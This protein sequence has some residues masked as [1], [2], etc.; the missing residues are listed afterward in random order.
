MINIHHFDK[1]LKTSWIKKLITQ[2]NSL[3][4]RLMT[5]MYENISQFLNFGDQWCNK[6]AQNVHNQF[7]LDVLK[8]W[9][10][11]IR[12]QQPQND[13][14][15]LRNC[16]WYNSQVSKNMIFFPDR[17][18]KGIYLVD[19]ITN[20]DGKLISIRDL[21]KKYNINVNIL[22]YYTIKVKIELFTSKYRLFGSSTLERPTYPFHLDALFKS[23]SGCKHYYNMFNNA[24]AQNENPT[25]EI[26]WTNIIE[27]ENLDITIKERWK[28]IYKICF[29][30]VH[31]NNVI[32]FQYRILNNILGT[33]NYLK[34]VKINMN[35]ACSF[36]KTHD[37]TL[38]HLFCK[39]REVIQLWNNIQQWIN[40]KSSSNKFNETTRLYN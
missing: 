30:S 6:I 32:W 24:E 15:L 21:N 5:I 14:E 3:W 10:T 37:E 27:K 17:Y 40:N 33:K 31:D 16:I 7:W 38:E 35:S 9:Q 4:Y 20:S 22:N 12:I 29:Y 1:M 11:L 8:D 19:D 23:K 36:C 13:C 34:K 28:R 26:I 25:C 39:C 2:P 18:K